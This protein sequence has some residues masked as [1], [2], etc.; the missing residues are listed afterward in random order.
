MTQGSEA[1][2]EMVVRRDGRPWHRAAG[3]AFILAGLFLGPVTVVD[4]ARGDADTL[5]LDIARISPFVLTGLCV[6]AFRSGLS[7]RASDRKAVQW[8]RWLAWGP[9]R[10]VDLG[11]YTRVVIERN[12]QAGQGDIRYSV[13]LA[14]A[15][16]WRLYVVRAM[17]SHD[18]AVS[19]ADRI[20][21]FLAL[22]RE[23]QSHLGAPGGCIDA[24]PRD[25]ELNRPLGP[26]LLGFGLAAAVGMSVELLS[27]KSLN[28][29]GIGIMQLV[30]FYGLATVLVLG[31]L[32]MLFS[33]S[34]AADDAAKKSDSD[35]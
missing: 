21:A 22:P 20:G 2:D 9:E 15:G 29:G 28:G 16:L 8:Q 23:D 7:L 14:D 5:L 34:V 27:P 33:D 24:V 19:L 4:L 30:F 10:E 12:Q 32:F 35:I 1:Q 17:S 3:A 25:E 11:A 18:G 6:L 26:Y 13:A 31:G